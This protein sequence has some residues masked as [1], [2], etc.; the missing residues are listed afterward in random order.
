MEGPLAICVPAKLL[1]ENSIVQQQNTKIII[2][3]LEKSLLRICVFNVLEMKITACHVLLFPMKLYFFSR[4]L[5][6]IFIII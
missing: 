2:I 1:S 3:K 6:N 5:F 4:K